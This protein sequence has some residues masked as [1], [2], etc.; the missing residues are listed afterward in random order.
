[1]CYENTSG[2]SGSQEVIYVGVIG[3][4]DIKTVTAPNDSIFYCNIMVTTG[5]LHLQRRLGYGRGFN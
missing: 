3:T 2:A 4:S 5:T 1:M